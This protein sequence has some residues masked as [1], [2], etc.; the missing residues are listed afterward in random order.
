MFAQI[1]KVDQENRIVYGRAAQ[2]GV[3]DKTD[4][5]FD[6]ETSKPYFQQWSA[7]ASDA[8][9]GL[10][11]GNVRS[12][13]G[14]VATG[15]LVD[16]QFDDHDQAI[17]VAA[18]IVDDNEWQKVLGG[19]YTGF[20]IGGR[21]IKRWPDVVNGQSVTRYTAVPTEISIVDRPCIPTAKFFDIQKADGRVERRAFR[22]SE[23]SMHTPQDSDFCGRSTAAHL[24]KAALTTAGATDA[25]GQSAAR[26]ARA[27]MR[28]GKRVL[29]DLAK[30]GMGIKSPHVVADSVS[31][32]RDIHSGGAQKMSPVSLPPES[33][34]SAPAP[35]AIHP[36][37]VPPQGSQYRTPT[38]SAPPLFGA[39]PQSASENEPALP[40]GNRDQYDPTVAAIKGIH[41]EGPIRGYLR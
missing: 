12:M 39:A 7:E 20:S 24:I 26:S 9:R 27:P 16:I 40:P 33:D 23:V 41:R 28:V 8:T 22:N 36:H 10:S 5:V 38:Y 21:Y 34:N 37:V 13:H 31:A 1:T 25:F 19:V 3:V 11:L 32:I 17:D 35:T 18:K 4:E 30:A 29:A 6:Y 2:D 15:K 14:N